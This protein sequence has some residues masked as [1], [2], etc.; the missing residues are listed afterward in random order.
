M[1][2]FKFIVYA[3]LI[4]YRLM[5]PSTLWCWRISKQNI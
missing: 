5:T 3:L 1:R 4:G 2:G